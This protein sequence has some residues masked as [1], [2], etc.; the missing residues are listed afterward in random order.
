MVRGIAVDGGDG[1]GRRWRSPWPAARCGPRS[2]TGSRRRWR[3]SPGVTDV[4]RRLHRDDRRGAGGAARASS[5]AIRRRRPAPPQ[6]MGHAE[7]ATP[8]PFADPGSNTR[9]IGIASGKGGVGKS[10][11]T[12]NLAVALAHRGH[13]RPARR[14]RVRVLA[15]P[16]CSASTSDPVQIDEMLIP[17]EANGVRLHLDGLL[18]R[19]GHSPSS[20][21]ARCCTRRSSSSSPTSTGTSPTSCSSTCRPGTGDVALSLRSTC[22]QAEVIVVTTPQPAA[23]RVAQRSGVHGGQGRHP[24]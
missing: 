8:I 14:R 12:V 11:V 18:R 4:D 22:P 7:G 19:G 10:S 6:A 17:P 2:P 9:C 16:G 20:G 15:S 24:A 1:A 21:G 23:Q 13:G 5:R 3:R